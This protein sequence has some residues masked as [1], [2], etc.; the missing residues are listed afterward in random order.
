MQGQQLQQA[1]ARE[2]DADMMRQINDSI[3]QVCAAHS[4][5]IL[6][7]GHVPACCQSSQSHATRVSLSANHACMPQATR[8]V[9]EDMLAKAGEGVAEAIQ[10][11][12]AARQA[13]KPTKGGTDR[14]Q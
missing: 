9:E 5:L 12:K 2:L 7:A 14:Q 1:T 3:A 8:L 6:S 11:H 10:E 13:V 4:H